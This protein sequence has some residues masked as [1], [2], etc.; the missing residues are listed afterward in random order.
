M[1]DFVA[2]T[3]LAGAAAVKD[4]NPHLSDT[5]SKYIK[6]QEEFS[7]V[8]PAKASSALDCP[9]PDFKGYNHKNVSLT[10]TEGLWMVDMNGT[11][12]MQEV[13]AVDFSQKST[14]LFTSHASDLAGNQGEEHKFV[15]VV[16][17]VQ[18]PLITA[19]IGDTNTTGLDSVEAGTTWRITPDSTSTDNFDGDL[20]Q[21][22]RYSIYHKSTATR[23]LVGD[24]QSTISPHVLSDS[25]D[26]LI[27]NADYQDAKETINT[28]T[29]G[30]FVVQLT[31]HDHAGIYGWNGESNPNRIETEVTIADTIAPEIFV[32]GENPEWT[33]CGTD[34]IEAGTTVT[35]SF[36][37]VARGIVLN[38]S[39]GA[40]GITQGIY[41]LEYTVSDE[42]G[43]VAVS[44]TRIVNVVD[45]LSPTITLVGQKHATHVAGQPFEDG[46]VTCTDQCCA[47]A[48]L[49][50]SVAWSKPWDG[51]VL[52]DYVRT[53]TCSDQAVPHPH[54]VTTTRTFTVEDEEI[55]EITVNGN[56]TKYVEAC[57]DCDTYVDQGA[58]CIDNVNMTTE[59]DITHNLVTKSNNVLR[60]TPGTYMVD[61]ECT[62]ASNNT[63]IPK[64][65]EVI[66]KDTTCP[67]ITVLGNLQERVEASFVYVDAG[68]TATDDFDGNITIGDDQTYGDTVDTTKYF[69]AMDSC[70]AINSQD[71]GATSGMYWITRIVGDINAQTSYKRVEVYCDMTHETI[72]TY[73]V[74]KGCERITPYVGAQGGC[75]AN[76]FTM[77]LFEHATAEQ[78]AK[79]IDFNVDGFD[80]FGCSG[81]SNCTTDNYLCSTADSDAPL[82]EHERQHW[83]THSRNVDATKMNAQKGVFIIEYKVKDAAGNPNCLPAKRTVTVH[84]TL[85]PIV[86]LR[87]NRK[88]SGD[89]EEEPA[90]Q[91]IIQVSKFTRKGIHDVKNPAGSSIAAGNTLFSDAT[92][93]YNGDSPHITQGYDAL[94]TNPHYSYTGSESDFDS[95]LVVRGDGGASSPNTFE[96]STLMAEETTTSSNSGYMFAASGFA[97]AGLA[98]LAQASKKTATTT[99]PV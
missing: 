67:R 58:T 13:Q 50:I 93:M 5:Y 60:N 43:N 78:A 10:S 79:D 72:P 49:N 6:G 39:V 82:T 35:D 18:R 55:P 36:D 30:T 21:E 41:P 42:A 1:R 34:Y 75:T 81:H 76:G 83:S 46:G 47:T 63:A 16:D 24:Y 54:T 89:D 8:C 64:T 11:S 14:Y 57:R 37:T 70:A 9:L 69:L 87:L 48:D 86:T 25:D 32:H 20:S 19:N 33:E 96:P 71:A 99:V 7:T 92:P 17:D 23:A 12:M 29:T 52:G 85:V 2:L 73:F 66:V 97:A 44:K 38:A 31:V 90:S 22:I 4:S 62:D 91:R 84:D 95:A 45:T 88:W 77:P 53:Y 80:A 61:F 74:C 40:P 15:I 26:Y 59:E 98:L 3:L 94:G 27:S 68:A 56:V 28:M 65:R 51:E